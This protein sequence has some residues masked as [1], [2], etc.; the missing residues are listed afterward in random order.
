MCKTVQIQSVVLSSLTGPDWSKTTVSFFPRDP[1]INIPCPLNFDSVIL[2][3]HTGQVKHQR[4]NSSV[5]WRA[6]IGK[7][8][9]ALLRTMKALNFIFRKSFCH[10]NSTQPYLKM[11]LFSQTQEFFFFLAHQVFCF[12]F[13]RA[14]KNSVPFKDVD[15]DKYSVFPVSIKSNQMFTRYCITSYKCLSFNKTR[16]NS[17]LMYY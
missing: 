2:L 12:L 5:G 1:N 16:L 15:S 6:D 8:W 17:I 10:V 13:S 9:L 3:P 11:S 4:E 14:I 7:V